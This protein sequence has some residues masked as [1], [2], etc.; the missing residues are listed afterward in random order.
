M[1]KFLLTLIST[2][3][4][5]II[6]FL[7][8][9]LGGII[10]EN[11]KAARELKEFYSWVAS[12]LCRLLKRKEVEKVKGDLTTQT[13]HYTFDRLWT[14]IPQKDKKMEVR[15]LIFRFLKGGSELD[16]IMEDKKF[17]ELHEWLE[18]KSK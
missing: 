11:R 7:G 2:L 8:A 15:A 18:K 9:I 16:K 13:L 14:R 1:D 6:G 5:A 4:G 10:A 12:L 3:I 17:R